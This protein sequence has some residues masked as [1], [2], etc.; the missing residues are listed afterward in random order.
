MIGLMGVCSH[1]LHR[2]HVFFSS[3]KFSLTFDHHLMLLAYHLRVSCSCARQR[4]SV[5][6]FGFFGMLFAL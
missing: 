6:L 2:A 1:Y 4:Q 3:D 5:Y